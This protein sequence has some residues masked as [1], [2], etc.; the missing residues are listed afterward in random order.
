MERRQERAW[1]DWESGPTVCM[2]VFSVLSPGLGEG[3]VSEASGTK[4]KGA[5][6]QK[7]ENPSV[8]KIKNV[9]VPY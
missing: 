3:E 4:C 1:E 9:L 5:Q 2:S 6:R 7:T 8:I